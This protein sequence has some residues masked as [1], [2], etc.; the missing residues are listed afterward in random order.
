M[1]VSAMMPYKNN[2]SE[3]FKA[4]F[5]SVKNILIKKT[6]KNLYAMERFAN[7]FISISLF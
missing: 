7:K 3:Q 4:F 2:F 6:T 1:G 5:L